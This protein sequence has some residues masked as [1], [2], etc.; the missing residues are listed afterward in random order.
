MKINMKIF[1]LITLV[2]S[3]SCQRIDNVE[4]NLVNSDVHH[5][6]NMFLSNYA[7]NNLNKYYLEDTLRGIDSIKDIEFKFAAKIYF[8]KK[9]IDSLYENLPKILFSN[10]INVYDTLIY[11]NSGL[12]INPTEN[13]RDGILKEC[14][15]KI[16][17]VLRIKQ[18]QLIEIRR[19]IE[20]IRVGKSNEKLNCQNCKDEI[21]LIQDNPSISYSEFYLH[22][23]KQFL[24]VYRELSCSSFAIELIVK[25][26]VAKN[27][28]TVRI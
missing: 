21:I 16:L 13:V 8:I 19:Q 9:T 22:I 24:I 17:T 25:P 2:I 4:Q 3:L 11:R 12:I 7:N 1:F 23:E 18:N 27:N 15:N 28:Y 20:N 5:D 6:L 26:K 14:N 10:K